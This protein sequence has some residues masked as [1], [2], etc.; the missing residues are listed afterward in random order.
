M[1]GGEKPNVDELERRYREIVEAEK[2][3]LTASVILLCRKFLSR[4]SEP[5]Y[6]RLALAKALV[7]LGRY[8][9]AEGALEAAIAR[10]P[11]GKRGHAPSQLGHLEIARGD[12]AKARVWYERAHDEDPG[13]AGPL[14][15]L[16]CAFFD[17]GYPRQAELAFRRAVCCPEG[18]VEEAYHNLG[19][20]LLAQ[21][22]FKEAKPCFDKALEVDPEYE[23]ARCKL[24]D[25]DR[26]LGGCG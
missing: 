7:R 14:I 26:I 23:V 16:G 17:E 1:G 25:V 4:W 24:R 6:V 20:A 11:Q 13:E 9:E 21:E 5:E 22:R 19:T 18:H 8:K 12:F 10:R 2:S 15:D 3:R